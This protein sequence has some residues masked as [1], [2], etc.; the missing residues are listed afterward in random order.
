[1][2]TLYVQE[3]TTCVS[4]VR[5]SAKNACTYTDCDDDDDGH[6]IPA[7]LLEAEEERKEKDKDEV[8]RL[9]HGV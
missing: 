7:Q 8:G 5:A 1:M 2:M 9:A 3:A 4:R 6:E